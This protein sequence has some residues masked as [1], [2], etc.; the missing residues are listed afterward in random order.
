MR[1]VNLKETRNVLI[2]E[3]TWTII[4]DLAKYYKKISEKKIKNI[5][6]QYL[7][8]NNM[9]NKKNFYD[10]TVKYTLKL[11]SVVNGSNSC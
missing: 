10:Y 7:N 6:C 5:Y 9:R 3:T 1:P 4:T 11:N 2:T 8:Y